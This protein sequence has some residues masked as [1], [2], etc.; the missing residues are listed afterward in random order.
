VSANR[1]KQTLLLG[2]HDEPAAERI[3]AVLSRSFLVQAA[4][5]AEDAYHK[6]HT[7]D[8]DLAVLDYA[9][10]KIN[11]INLHEGISFLHAN[12]G[13]VICVTEENYAVASRVWS[14]RAV[15]FI[16]KPYTETRFVQDVMK[17]MRYILLHKE[18][19]QMR[20]QIRTLEAEKALLES[21]NAERS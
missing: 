3:F 8:P 2:L 17:V 13:V 16:F 5:D 10:P 14:K 18:N 6:I 19:E 7:L 1:K 21:D 9:L 15:D 12:V 20:T 11:P 4:V